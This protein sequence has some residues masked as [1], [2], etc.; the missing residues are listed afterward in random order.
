MTDIDTKIL[1]AIREDADE[2]IQEYEEELGL[3]GLIAESFR[4][5]FRWTVI[6]SILLQAAFLVVIVYCAIDFFHTDEISRKLDLLAIGLAAFI[7]FGLL[8]LW[9]LMEL[10]RLSIRREIKRL[11]LQVALIGNKL[12]PADS[13]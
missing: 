8:R 10:N 6:F 5:A 4:G 13:D 2:A 1:E 3:F 11:E 12:R 7:A 9:F